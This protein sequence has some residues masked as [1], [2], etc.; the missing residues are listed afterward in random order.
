MNPTLVLLAF[1]VAILILLAGLTR[2]EEM[3]A[4]RGSAFVL[5]AVLAFGCGVALAAVASR[6]ALRFAFH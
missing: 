4:I 5:V 3:R 2:G 6:D 1:P